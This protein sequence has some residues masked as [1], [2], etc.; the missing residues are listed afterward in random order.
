MGELSI[1]LKKEKYIVT[2]VPPQSYYDIST[3]EFNLS[4]LNNY[5]DFHPEFKYHGRNTYAYLQAKFGKYHK[6]LNT[7][8]L[9]T[10]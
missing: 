4:L 10:V 1:L 5:P 9:I 2:I 6:Y 8:D 7:F 3:S